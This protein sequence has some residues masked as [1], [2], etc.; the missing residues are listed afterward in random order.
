MNGLIY[1]HDNDHKKQSKLKNTR[2][3]KQKTIHTKW[4]TIHH[5]LTFPEPR[6]QQCGGDFDREQNTN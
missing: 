2:I 6:H 5:G 4:I 1:N 3:N